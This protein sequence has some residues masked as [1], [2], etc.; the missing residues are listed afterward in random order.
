MKKGLKKSVTF[1]E[2]QA[3]NERKVL[4]A[5][6]N[7]NDEQFDISM[8][9]L[10]FKDVK[11]QNEFVDY[12]RKEVLQQ[13]CVI[14]VV[15]FVIAVASLIVLNLNQ[16]DDEDQRKLLQIICLEM[17]GS[18]GFLFVAVVISTAAPCF[19]EFFGLSIQLPFTIASYAFYLM[20][21]M[22]LVTS[23]PNF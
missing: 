17:C 10:R 12:I 7:A 19:I 21:Q 18:T 2:T 6:A 8:L 22:K 4:T 16:S 20:P 5:A 23:G 9:T 13:T 15:Y 14:L 3:R 1:D 11:T